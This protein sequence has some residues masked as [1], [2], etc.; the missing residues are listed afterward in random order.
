MVLVGVAVLVVPVFL[1]G[2]AAPGETVTRTLVLPGQQ[3]AEMQRKTIRVGDDPRF[4]LP[5]SDGPSA[6]DRP[7]S[8]A[9]DAPPPS[10][11][12][13]GARERPQPAGSP[14][15]ASSTSGGAASGQEPA[16]AAATATE[17]AAAGGARLWAVQLGSFSD[18]RN[19]ERLAAKLRE[20]GFP[21]FLSRLSTDDG[22]LQRVRVGPQKDRE[23]AEQ[24]ARRLADLGQRG[25][26]VAHP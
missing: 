21:A 26:V 14:Q 22:A 10:M 25:Q 9:N 24:V 11:E 15:E 5:E 13:A 23:S 2:P 1:D 18:A 19:A 8:S 16:P 4:A 12:N 20:Q 17:S 3:A 7:A 6:G